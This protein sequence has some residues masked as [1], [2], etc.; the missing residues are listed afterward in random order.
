MAPA[1]AAML[2]ELE[3]ARGGALVLGGGVVLALALGAEE[4][5]DVTH[6]VFL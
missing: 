2:I 1:G 4:L 5:N 3:L 6:D